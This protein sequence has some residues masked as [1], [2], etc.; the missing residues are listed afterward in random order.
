MS[1]SE[2]ILKE[3]DILLKALATGVILVFVY[4]LLR[5]IRRLIPHGTFW[6]ALEDFLFWAGSAI[7]IFAMLYREN[8]GYLRGFSI[9]GVVI[10][11][12]L[13]SMLLSR[14]IVRGS[15]FILEKI[16]YV[17][18]R[19]LVY[20][21]RLLQKPLRAGGRQGRK[22]ARFMKKRLKKLWKTVRMGLCKM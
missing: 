8:D 19:P 16:L 21:G 2:G 10:G 17:L 4:D 20:I 18:F 13:Y 5:I 15:V 6:I 11:M 22:F 14:F 9:G 3:A 12:L 7:A 1:V